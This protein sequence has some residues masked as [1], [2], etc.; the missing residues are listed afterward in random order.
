MKELKYINKYFKKYGT[1]IIVRIIYLPL[2]PRVFSL[3][4]PSYVKKSIQ[5]VEDYGK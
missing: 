3:V 1:P 2:L 5:V 4:T